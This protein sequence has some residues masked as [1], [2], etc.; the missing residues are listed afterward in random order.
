MP[1]A[2]RLS[3]TLDLKPTVAE[4]TLEK[5]AFLALGWLLGLLG[6]I[7][8]DAIRRRRENAL[9][10]VAILNEL[11][12]LAS[13]LA[14][15][16]FG[17]RMRQGT[18]DR[19]F[20]EWLKSDLERHAT[21]QQLQAFIPSLRTQLSWSDEELKKIAIHMSSEDGTGLVLQHYPVPLLDARVSAI[22][23]FDTSFQRGLLEVRQNLHLLDDLVDRSRKYHD[24]TF[25]LEG[26][27]R[28]LVEENFVQACA[29]Y[30]ERA[31]RTVDLIRRLVT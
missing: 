28:R 27:N 25:T 23:S 7:I 22:W 18:A 29:L 20:L 15:A 4:D 26:E 3:Q 31:Q 11:R 1:T 9:G 16:A 19:R 30:A 5:L 12:E 17:A 13:V 8:V 14:T 21:S 6:P 24:Q 10:R 2:C